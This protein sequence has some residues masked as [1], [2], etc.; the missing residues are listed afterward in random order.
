MIKK[1]N[2]DDSK[3]KLSESEIEAARKFAVAL[4]KYDEDDPRSLLFTGFET[5]GAQAKKKKLKNSDL[6]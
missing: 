3:A 6:L 1:M 2:T 5:R 4:A